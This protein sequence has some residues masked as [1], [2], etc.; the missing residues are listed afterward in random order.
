MAETNGFSE[1]TVR[2]QKYPLLF[3]FAAAQEMATRSMKNLS[4]NSVKNL[5]DLIYSGMLNE[6]ISSDIPLPTYSEA[7]QI[8]ELF[9]LENNAK[10]QEKKIWEVFLQSRWGQDYAKAIEKAKKKIPKVMS[11]I[12]KSA[13]TGKK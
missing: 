11:E 2:G 8:T 6:A 3:G 5:T 10:E 9:A 12:A 7:Y 1:I 13:Q 4:D